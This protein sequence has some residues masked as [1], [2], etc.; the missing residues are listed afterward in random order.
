MRE[1]D[2]EAEVSASQRRMEFFEE[3]SIVRKGGRGEGR[4]M[5][6]TFSSVA[7]RTIADGVSTEISDYLFNASL[8]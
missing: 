8:K 6:T 5:A 4:T 1:A 3:R 7:G 2:L